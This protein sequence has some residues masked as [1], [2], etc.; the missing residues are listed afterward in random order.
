[1]AIK[2]SHI[3]KRYGREAKDRAIETGVLNDNK[4]SFWYHGN[5]EY[6]LTQKGVDHFRNIFTGKFLVDYKNDVKLK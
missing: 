1:M 4:D 3:E 5:W 2:H 6:R